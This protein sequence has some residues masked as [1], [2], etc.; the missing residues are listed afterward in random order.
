LQN[1]RAARLINRNMEKV[2]RLEAAE[3]L[4]CFHCTL[5]T[6]KS[7]ID[8]TSYNSFFRKKEALYFYG[9]GL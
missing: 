5:N 9:Y 1:K 2:N 8:F 6:I 3:S 4:P 7:E